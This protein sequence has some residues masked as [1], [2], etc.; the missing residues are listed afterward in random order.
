[1]GRSLPCSCTLPGFGRRDGRQ[2]LAA[3]PSVAEVWACLTILLGRCSRVY[4]SMALRPSEAK[5]P[6]LRCL[7]VP[8]PVQS[9]PAA[10]SS[11]HGERARAGS[12][13]LASPLGGRGCWKGIRLAVPRTARDT[14]ALSRA[15]SLSCLLTDPG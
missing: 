14:Q 9:V 3:L 6:L 7:G 4:I 13:C 1:M 2:H 15:P 8:A 11:L 5:H 10:G 12:V